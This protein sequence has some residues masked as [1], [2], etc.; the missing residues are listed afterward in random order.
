[1][2]TDL[3]VRLV[4]GDEVRAA[5]SRPAIRERVLVGLATVSSAANCLIVRDAVEVPDSAFF[6][7]V[8][9]TWSHRFTMEQVARA[10]D[11]GTGICIV[12]SHGGRGHP[13]LS[14]PDMDNF[15]SLAP[16]V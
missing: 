5:L 2:K 3:E 15:W 9:A 10:A 13:R 12:H 8:E 16:A 11:A 14:G 4:G 6:G 1:M 7:G